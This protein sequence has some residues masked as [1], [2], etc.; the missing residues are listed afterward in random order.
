[1]LQV[2]PD[3][4]A[5]EMRL[6]AEPLGA[7]VQSWAIK[8]LNGESHWPVCYALR[9]DVLSHSTLE[10]PSAK[11]DAELACMSLHLLYF[12]ART[13]FSYCPDCSS[14]NGSGCLHCDDPSY[15][16]TQILGHFDVYP[17]KK[18]S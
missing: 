14:L 16:A 12:A 6:V 9:L 10:I 3:G 18:R 8:V 5:T 11:F 13:Q 15:S 17:G 2:G 4:R 7:R 1:M